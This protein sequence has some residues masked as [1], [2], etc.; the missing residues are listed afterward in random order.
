MSL[1]YEV[2]SD[3]L[4]SLAL[5]RSDGTLIASEP[6]TQE[7][8]NAEVSEQGWFL[9]ARK[10]IENIQ[11]SLPHIQNLFF[12]GSYRYHRVISFST[13]VDINDGNQPGMGVLLVDFKYSAIQDA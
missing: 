7:K 12:D 5:Y 6:V 9:G 11:I 8:E 13:A 3:Q 1:L 10:D 2:H 4:Q